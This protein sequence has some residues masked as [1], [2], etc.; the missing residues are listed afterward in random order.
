MIEM[1][2]L[3]KDDVSLEI[4]FLAILSEFF[5]DVYFQYLP[6]LNEKINN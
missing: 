3:G 5:G 2:L 1:I 4:I 6:K